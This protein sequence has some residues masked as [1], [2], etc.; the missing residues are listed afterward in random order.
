MARFKVAILF[1]FTIFSTNLVDAQAQ[2][3]NPGPVSLC[4]NG[5]Y[6]LSPTTIN[7]TFSSANSSVATVDAR[8]Y[9]TG[10]TDGTTEISLTI[11]GGGTIT[12]SVTVVSTSSITITDP[13]ALPNY[14]FDNNPHGPIGGTINYVGYKGFTYSSQTQPTNTG[15]YR[16]SKQVGNDAGCPVPFYII[17]C[18]A[19]GDAYTPSQSGE[20]LNLDV[21]NVSSYLGSGNS[22]NDLSGSHNNG[23][24]YNVTYESNPKSFVF[25]GSSSRISFSNGITS[26]DNLTYEAWIYRSDNSGVIAN[27]NGWSQGYVHF[28]FSG[29][30]LQFALNNNGDNDRTS[31]FVFNLNTWYHV[32]VTY[33]KTN[34]TVSFYVNGSLKN[35]ENYSSPS[36]ITQNAFT[37]GAWN[38]NGS[39][40][41]DRFFNGKIAVFRA[42]NVALNDTQVQQNFN[43]LKSRFGL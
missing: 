8:G 39:G 35:V 29:N 3:N 37:I 25:N 4:I 12:A 10:I 41:F 1:V 14:K 9:V 16:A 7:G 23:T 11:T 28:Q 15:Y 31:N 38:A 36:S 22:W 26:G 32:A 42:Y 40:V 19:C 17:K 6:Y 20:V 24:L 34:N 21:G 43:S 33:S 5:S 18:D 27:L 2:F 30:T 13:T